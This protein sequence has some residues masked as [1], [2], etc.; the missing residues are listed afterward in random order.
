[1]AWPVNISTKTVVGTFYDMQT[2]LP[3]SGS[4]TFTP[5]PPNGV[6]FLD[7]AATTVVVPTP[8]VAQMDAN[9]AISVVL[10]CTD[11]PDLSPINWT[12]HAKMVSGTGQVAEFDFSLPS[13]SPATVDL[14]AIINVPAIPAPPGLY[15]KSVNGITPN[16][17][18]DVTV[19]T[20]APTILDNLSDVNAPTPANLNILSFDL[21]SGTWIKSGRLT[22]VEANMGAWS[23]GTAISRIQGLENARAVRYETNTGTSCANATDTDIP[24]GTVVRADT[25]LFTVSGA[26]YTCVKTGFVDAGTCI[27]MAAGTT[28]FELKIKLNGTLVVGT[29]GLT[30]LQANI[31]T[32]FPVTAGDVI[33]TSVFHNSGSAKPLETGA[34]RQNHIVLEYRG[35]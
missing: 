15:V 16:V 26:N 21:A 32:G 22:T 24:F 10:P 31:W 13:A 20:I 35:T 28:G 1:M 7:P 19:F 14:S 29:N 27:R 5:S 17:N 3:A 18:G 8:T 4:V 25:S 34:G 2:E 9:G 12:W 6:W 11:D 33:K 23:G 30:G